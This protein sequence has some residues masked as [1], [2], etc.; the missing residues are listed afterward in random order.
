MV[1]PNRGRADVDGREYVQ[2]LERGLSVLSA[3]RHRQS[4]TIAQVAAQTG[5][6][7]AVARRYL[8]TLRSLGCV[9]DRNGGFALTPRVLD[10]GFI[11]LSTSDVARLAEPMLERIVETLHESCSA[12]VLDGTE[13]VY[14]AR[15]PAKR[16]MS[17]P[18]TVGSR[19]PAHATSLGKVLLAA[20]EQRELDAYFARQPLRALTANTITDQAQLR[21]VLAGVRRAGWASS[22][23]E[24]EAG[25]RTVAAP[26]LGPTNRV[27]AAINITGHAARVTMDQLQRV[28]LP[29]LL[30]GAR[31]ISRLLGAPSDPASPRGS[32][33]AGF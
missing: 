12:A 17:V 25:V 22:D 19:L 27:Q 9:A 26:L 23:E 29:V 14:L 30:E 32:M 6:T 13:I 31:H 7:R 16:I 20:L 21:R 2:G 4:M 18:L 24:C 8:L 11:Y 15:V 28:Y 10:L 33:T 5:L 1:L 3:F